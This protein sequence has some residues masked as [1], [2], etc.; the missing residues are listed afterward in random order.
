[1]DHAILLTQ[2]ISQGKAM[3]L[4]PR[5][6]A[7]LYAVYENRD[8]SRTVLSYAVEWESPGAAAEYFKSYR[9][10]LSKK[11]KK[12]EITSESAV[13]ITGSGDDGRFVVKHEGSLVTSL[14]GLP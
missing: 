5:W 2:Y 8:R 10:V 4:A 7:G 12:M 1:L 3:E 14:E 13:E 9:E 6:R 11:W